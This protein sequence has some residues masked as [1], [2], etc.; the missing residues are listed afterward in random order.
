MMEQTIVFVSFFKVNGEFNMKAFNEIKKEVLDIFQTE[1][2]PFS[3]LL[4][5]GKPFNGYAATYPEFKEKEVHCLGI[6]LPNNTSPAWT[7]QLNALIRY[8]DVSGQVVYFTF[9]YTLSNTD[10]TIGI[11]DNGEYKDYFNADKKS[12]NL[13]NYLVHKLVFPVNYQ[14]SK[15]HEWVKDSSKY[16]IHSAEF[17]E[18]FN[19]TLDNFLSSIKG[20]LDSGKV[21]FN[22][23][24]KNQNKLL[25][26]ENLHEVKNKYHK[27][28]GYINDELN[29]AVETF[30]GYSL[31]DAMGKENQAELLYSYSELKNIKTCN[32][33]KGRQNSSINLILP[34]SFTPNAVNKLSIYRFINKDSDLFSTDN[35]EWLFNV[36]NHSAYVE[37]T[38]KGLVF[39]EN[40][41]TDKIKEQS[42]VITFTLNLNKLH[43]L[44]LDMPF[45]SVEYDCAIKA[46]TREACAKVQEMVKDVDIDSLNKEEVKAF[47]TKV[48]LELDK[49]RDTR[50]KEY[51]G[52]YNS[53]R[54]TD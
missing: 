31:T 40:V 4:K 35:I 37:G 14:Q 24:N 28:Y 52:I 44:D 15:S 12:D 21:D 3:K 54:L 39:I 17:K 45:D 27:T 18:M 13:R 34:K 19:S 7:N 25:F 36:S 47:T 48:E 26:V 50:L 49:I 32:G 9:D 41:N 1:S 2:H 53:R 29:A 16:L 38:V 33:D 5:L 30:T 46:I 22:A 42:N 23:L 11:E 6:L 20:I 10:N 8:D 43:Y 51:S